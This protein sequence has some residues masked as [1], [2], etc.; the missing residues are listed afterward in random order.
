MDNIIFSK[1]SFEDLINIKESI[2]RKDLI[3]SVVVLN[4]IIDDI[5]LLKEEDYKHKIFIDDF[6]Y[7]LTNDKLVFYKLEEDIKIIRILESNEEI[8]NIININN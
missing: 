8:L 1:K 5:Y 6:Y 7:F 3:Q 2:G 4:Q